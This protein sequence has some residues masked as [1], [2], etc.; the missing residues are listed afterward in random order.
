MLAYAARV[1]PARVVQADL[2]RLPLDQTCAALGEMRRILRPGGW[3]A[4][5]TAA[6]HDRGT[7]IPALAQVPGPRGLSR[8]GGN[9]A[10]GQDSGPFGLMSAEKV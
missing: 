2:R 1:L 10:R 5:V 4:L 7:R 3:L 9:G 8:R 6:G